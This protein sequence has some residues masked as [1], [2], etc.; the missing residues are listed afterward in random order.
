MLASA[1]RA[2][3]GAEVRTSRIHTRQKR[4]N[5]KQKS[6]KKRPINTP[7]NTKSWRSHKM[8]GMVQCRKR[9][10]V[11]QKSPKKRPIN[12]P[13]STGSLRSHRMTGMVQCSLEAAF[14]SS[15]C[16]GTHLH[17]IYIVCVCVCARAR[18]RERER[19]RERDRERERESE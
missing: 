5:V 6:P 8:T 19:E 15:I 14:I 17:H 3:P 18:E 16:V 9:P 7:H 12:T 2:P 11:E 4:P 10:D 13:D 1:F